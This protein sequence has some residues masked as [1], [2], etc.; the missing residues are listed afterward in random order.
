MQETETRLVG[1]VDAGRLMSYTAA[2]A[3]WVRLSGTPEELAA[4]RWVEQQLTEFGLKTQLIMH[5][6]YISPPGQATLTVAGL[7]PVAAITH[8]MAVSDAATVEIVTGPEADAEGKI[9]LVD[10]LATPGAVLEAQRRGARALLVVGDANPH[11]MIVS[12][13]W[14]SPSADDLPRLPQIA[15]MS[16]AHADGERIRRLLAEGPVT[17]AYTTEVKTG[18]VKT[19]LL[20]ADLPGPGAE[21]VLFSGHLDSWYLGAMDNG[22]ANAV[23][24]EAARVLASARGELKRGL[25]LAFWSGH[26]H[27]RYSGSAWYADTHWQD[28]YENCVAHVNIDSVGGLNANVLTEAMVHPELLGLGAD[29]IRRYTGVEYVGRRVNRSSDQSFT[30]VGIPSLW[31]AFSEQPAGEDG[32]GAAKLFGGNSGGLGWWW[33]TVHDTVDKIDPLLLHRDCICFVA[34]L[35]R[36]LLSERLPM[37]PEAAAVAFRRDLKAYAEAGGDRVDLSGALERADRLV[38]LAAA[39]RSL[40]DGAF[41]RCARQVSRSLIPVGYTEAGPF[42]HDP[43]INGPAI[44]ALKR[45]GELAVTAPGSDAERF[46]RPLVT[47]GI[48]RVIF[49][50]E[51]AVAALTAEPS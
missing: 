19:P 48:N 34:A 13:V 41:N 2:I 51:Q 36:L 14:G 47:R 18:W 12:P 40:P 11:E 24:I 17:A 30:G 31:A 43:A 50:L 44:P 10:G 49:A 16:I 7:G 37:D 29:V 8:A 45:I 35:S 22:S 26:S 4:F 20:V 6:A 33:H 28:L 23:M 9:R 15:A 38:A 21:Y 32:V 5:D 3:R 42:G 27:G 46:L 39:V 1:A 25:R